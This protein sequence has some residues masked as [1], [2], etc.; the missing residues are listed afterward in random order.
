MLFK[1]GRAGSA[2]LIPREDSTV[3]VV[4]DDP[5]VIRSIHSLLK[6]RQLT[7]RSH[8]TTKAFLKAY[9]PRLPGCL[10]CDTSAIASSEQE[11]LGQLAD[12]KVRLPVIFVSKPV[13]MATVVGAMKAGALNYLEKPVDGESLWQ[14]ICE[15]LACD[16][17]NRA[18]RRH[19]GK[20]C[21]RLG[22]LTSGEHEVLKMLMDGSANREIA[23]SLGVSVRAIEVRRAKLMKKMKARSLPELV[24]LVLI[25]DDGR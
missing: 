5:P 13:E 8:P 24:R 10:V 21:R 12:G 4:A 15:A 20:I 14:A 3:Y 16:D 7:A 2:D 17:Q 1:T 9:D 19:V 23:D 18:H 22:D 11:L 6:S 25:A